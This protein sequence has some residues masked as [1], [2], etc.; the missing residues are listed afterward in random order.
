MSIEEIKQKIIEILKVKNIIS[1]KELLN[2]IEN[3]EDVEK[4]IYE[5]LSNNIIF[6]I[7]ILGGNYYGLRNF[8]NK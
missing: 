3:K 2:I 4:A 7:N 6:E 5:L 1:K 8:K